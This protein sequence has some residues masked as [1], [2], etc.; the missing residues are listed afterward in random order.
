MVDTI[1]KIVYKYIINDVWCWRTLFHG[2]RGSTF[3]PYDEW[4][5]ADC[6]L[7]KDGSG[8]Q[9]Y[10]SGIHC[11]K[12]RSIALKYKDKFKDAERKVIIKGLAKGL[13]QKPTNPDVWLADEIY[14][15]SPK[16]ANRFR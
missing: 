4:I 14:I 11:F 16:N 3:Q 1:F 15:P 13:R 8:G 7:V 9:A 10:L 5:E 2:I 6:K 12:D